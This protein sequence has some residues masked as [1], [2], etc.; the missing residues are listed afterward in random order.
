MKPMIATPVQA[1][2][3]NVRTQVVVI[4]EIAV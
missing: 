3:L 2:S 1:G 4:V